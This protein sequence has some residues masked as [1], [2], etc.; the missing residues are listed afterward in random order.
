MRIA[1]KYSPLGEVLWVTTHFFLSHHKKNLKKIEK[2]VTAV[3]THNAAQE[4]QVESGL[5]TNPFFQSLFCWISL[6]DS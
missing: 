3:T 4:V 1:L 2:K 6:N 5:S